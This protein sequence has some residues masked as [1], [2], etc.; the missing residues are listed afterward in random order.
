VKK[1]SELETDEIFPLELKSID[2]DRV[3][4]DANGVL[5]LDGDLWEPL[6]ITDL[7]RFTDAWNRSIALHDAKQKR[8]RKRRK[9]TPDESDTE[10]YQRLSDSLTDFGASK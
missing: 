9:H 5:T 10:T 8:T 6:Q 1:I 3:K 2:P 4:P 7:E